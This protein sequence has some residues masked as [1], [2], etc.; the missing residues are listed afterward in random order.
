[1]HQ[2]IPPVPI[3]PGN[4]GAFIRV[5]CPGGGAFV[6]PWAIPWEFNTLSFK[7]VKSPGR[8]VACFIPSRWRLSWEKI[9]ISYKWLV[10][11][12]LDKLVEIF[13]GQF[14][15]LESFPVF[16][17]S[18]Y[19]SYIIYRTIKETNAANENCV[20]HSTNTERTLLMLRFVNLN[21]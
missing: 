13:S 12:G 15:I 14:L 10:H 20:S 18:N 21:E 2:S 4:P 5:L 3:P 9:W 17:K 19:L 7:T 8:Q 6:H 1:M 11:E 16:Y